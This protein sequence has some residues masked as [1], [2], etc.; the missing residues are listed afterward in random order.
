M[1]INCFISVVE[2]QLVLLTSLHLYEKI[3]PKI[4][5]HIIIVLHYVYFPTYYCN[6]C[7]FMDIIHY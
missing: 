4:R 7:S 6:L 3:V 5:N 2:L 1:P